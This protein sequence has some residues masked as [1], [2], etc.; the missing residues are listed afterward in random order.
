MAVIVGLEGVLALHGWR[1][2]LI[3]SEGWD[4]YHKAAERD[5]PNQPVI[6]AIN[7]LHAKGQTIYCVATR[8]D[9]WR[10]M[11]LSW[12]VR[13]GAAVDTLLL[14]PEGNWQKDEQLREAALELI[15]R[16]HGDDVM[17]AI[18]ENEKACEFYRAAGVPVLQLFNPNGGV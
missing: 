18:E 6:Q 10:M 16:T 11:T 7:A 4:A 14:R 13:H 1:H 8:P 3:E 12:L 9:K 2:D 15:V 17:F 5:A